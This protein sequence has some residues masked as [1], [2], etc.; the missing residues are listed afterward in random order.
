[1]DK[2]GIREG[3][4]VEMMDKAGTKDLE[5]EVDVGAAL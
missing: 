5:V 2:G 1:L 3:G 4:E